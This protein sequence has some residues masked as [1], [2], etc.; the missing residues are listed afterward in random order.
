MAKK[1]AQPDDEQ[2]KYS[3]IIDNDILPKLKFV[4]EHYD[5]TAPAFINQQLA[6]IV[7]TKFQEIMSEKYDYEPR[8]K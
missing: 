1:A 7:E 8:K 5:Q 6:K 2:K 3:V 4:A